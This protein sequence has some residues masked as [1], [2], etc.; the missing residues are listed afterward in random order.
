MAWY[1]R[2]EYYER[3]VGRLFIAA[4]VWGALYF[5]G[6]VGLVVRHGRTLI[7]GFHHEELLPAERDDSPPRVRQQKDAVRP[8]IYNSRSLY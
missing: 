6:V 2:S 8:L 1:D 4:V 7:A 3:L 5:G